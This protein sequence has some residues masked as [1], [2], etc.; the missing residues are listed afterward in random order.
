MRYGYFRNLFGRKYFMFFYFLRLFYVK[1]IIKLLVR[2]FLF[3]LKVEFFEEGC[4]S[5]IFEN[6]VYVMFFKYVREILSGC[7]LLFLRMFL[8][9]LLVLVMN[10]FWVLVMKNILKFF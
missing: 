6:V 4:N 2:K 1:D 7:G 10:Y 8:N 5:C 9:L 3:L